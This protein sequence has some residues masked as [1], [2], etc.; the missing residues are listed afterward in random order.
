M[1]GELGVATRWF[2]HYGLIPT[3]PADPPREACV[4]R[5]LVWV[6]VRLVC[7]LLIAAGTRQYHGFH[8]F[9]ATFCCL[10]ALGAFT[11]PLTH[12]LGLKVKVK[13][14]LRSTVSLPV[15]PGRFFFFSFLKVSLD[16]WEF[17]IMGRPL[18]R[19]GGSLIYSWCW[20]S[21]GQS[22]SG[23]SS[24]G[25]VTKF[26]FLKFETP[27]HLEG[28]VPVLIYSRYRVAQFPSHWITC[29]CLIWIS[30]FIN[31]ELWLR[32]P[33][34]PSEMA[35]ARTQQRASLPTDFTS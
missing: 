25:F 22:F 8:R 9:M 23:P 26:Y 28:Q 20:V 35:L 31:T 15:Y 10:W 5:N 34:D 19:E 18:L 14:I 16:S 7:C 4:T 1:L 6:W 11:I 30:W 29:K 3:P 27:P 13:V 24:A 21:L 17:D 32:R 33:P 12:W 2:Q